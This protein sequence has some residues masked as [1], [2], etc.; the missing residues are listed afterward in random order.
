MGNLKRERVEESMGSGTRGFS[1]RTE[2]VLNAW[3]EK[4][5]K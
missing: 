2:R 3:I 1:V 4:A 5:E